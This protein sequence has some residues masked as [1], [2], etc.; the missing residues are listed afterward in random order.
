MGTGA[1]GVGR[2]PVARARPIR[3]GPAAQMK[4]VCAPAES[5]MKSVALMIASTPS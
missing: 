1:P 5:S 3:T 2:A 4:S